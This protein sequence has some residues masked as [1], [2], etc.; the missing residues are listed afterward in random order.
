[1]IR[2]SVIS[3]INHNSKLFPIQSMFVKTIVHDLV[4]INYE[5]YHPYYYFSEIE[6]TNKCKCSVQQQ[7]IQNCDKEIKY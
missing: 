1:M 5:S 6:K 2:E 4:C 7:V 3:F